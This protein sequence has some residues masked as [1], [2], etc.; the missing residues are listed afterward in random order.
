MNRPALT[1]KDRALLIRSP[2][3]AGLGDEA[4]DAILKTCSQRTVTRGETLF[5]QKEAATH[6][7]VV[8]EGWVKVYRLTAEGSEAVLHVFREGESLAEPAVF[9][10]K[11]YPASC[12]AVT[13]GRVLAMPGDALLGQI[14][15][16]P[17]LALRV[18]GVFSQ[19]LHSLVAE[20]ERRQVLSTPRR[21]ASFLLELL[22]P[23]AS[24]DAAIRVQLPFD[25]ALVAARLAMTPESFSRALARLREYGVTSRGA[26][27]EIHAPESLKRFIEGA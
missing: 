1:P 17:E 7:Y 2:M 8:L 3:F 18:I 22:P 4:F 10:L 23:G 6:L 19:R 11:H 5:V 21:V 25:K 13:D 27:V 16:N 26:E 20:T 24:Q 12:E 15:K 14:E 9:S